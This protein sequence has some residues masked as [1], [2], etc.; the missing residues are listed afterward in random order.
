M[1]NAIGNDDEVSR[2]IQRLTALKEHRIIFREKPI[3]RSAS[4]MQQEHRIRDMP[5]GIPLWNSQNHVMDFQLRQYFSTAKK[6]VADHKVR[7]R[8]LLRAQRGYK[9]KRQQHSEP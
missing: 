8:T 2:R 7:F 4:A 5:S 3:Q 6:E 9:K 1:T